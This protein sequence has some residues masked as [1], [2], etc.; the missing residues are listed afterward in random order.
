MLDTTFANADEKL[1]GEG[2]EK[3]EEERLLRPPTRPLTAA[4]AS[5]ELAFPSQKRKSDSSKN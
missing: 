3:T 1:G 4:E 2:R 5:T